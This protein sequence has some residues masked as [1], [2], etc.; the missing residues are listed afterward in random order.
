MPIKLTETKEGKILEVQASGKLT[1]EDYQHFTP[2]VER[3]LKVHGK[4]R[5]LFEMIDFHGWKGSAVWDD[6]KFDAK[7]YS[8]IE[9]LAFVGDKKWEKGMSV[10]CQPFTTAKIKYFD[11]AQMVDARKWLETGWPV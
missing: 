2:A 1:H 5:I 9:M 3:L 11:A 6:I 7:H 8:D 4:I 10:F